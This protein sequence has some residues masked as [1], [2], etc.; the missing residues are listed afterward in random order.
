[1]E[2]FAR[3]GQLNSHTRIMLLLRTSQMMDWTLTS[4]EIL[5]VLGIQFGVTQVIL[6]KDGNIVMKL[7]KPM[8]KVSGASQAQV[9]EEF[10]G[11]L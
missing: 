4:A 11:R 9:T 7:V 2:G 5:M 10:N 6:G 3:N 8:K 1:M